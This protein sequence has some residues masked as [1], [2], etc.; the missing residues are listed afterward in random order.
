MVFYVCCQLFQ[1]HY[2]LLLPLQEEP[3]VM[4]ANPQECLPFNF[5]AYDKQES[6]QKKNMY[7]PGVGRDQSLDIFAFAPL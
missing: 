2:I 7:D 6:G 3:R 1:H 5:E 4:N